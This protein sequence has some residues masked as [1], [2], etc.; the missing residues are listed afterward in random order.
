MSIIYTGVNKKSFLYFIK[1]CT[2]Q[3]SHCLKE[4]EI[5]YRDFKTEI[6]KQCCYLEKKTKLNWEN[7]FYEKETVGQKKK[8]EF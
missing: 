4:R 2:K 1:K 6:L 7:N 3:L 8:C 5:K